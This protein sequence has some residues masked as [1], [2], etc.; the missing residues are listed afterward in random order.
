MISVHAPTHSRSLRRW[1][2]AGVA[3][4]TVTAM[5][6]LGTVASAQSSVGLGTA[7]SYAILAGAAISNTGPSTINGDIGVSPGTAITGMDEATVNGATNAA[8][9]AALQAQSD[10]TI[11][12]N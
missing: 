4:T 11:A 12:Y 3:L 7:Q 2:V 1:L 9:A 8:N 5:T 10:L 6:M